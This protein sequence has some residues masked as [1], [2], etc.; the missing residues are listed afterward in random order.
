M[1]DALK[2]PYPSLLLPAEWEPQRAVWFTWPQ[3]AETWTPVW[4]E[5]RAAYRE[6]I[7]AAV[8]CQDVNVLVND[9]ATRDRLAAEFADAALGPH[10]LDFPVY[11]TNDSWIRDYGAIT[12][13]APAPGGGSRLLALDFGFNSWGGKYPPWDK[14]DAAPRFMAAARGRECL[15]VDLVLE[16]GSIDANG[17][18]LLLTTS[19]CLLNP[20]R[21]PGLDRGKLETALHGWLGAERVLWLDSGI[22]GDDTD[23][24]VD[25]LARFADARTVLC[26]IETDQRDENYEPLKRN[27]E[28]L[29]RAARTIDLE[30]IEIP[31]PARLV[32]ADLRTPAT[33]LNF[34]ILNG[35][36]LVPV[37]RDRRDD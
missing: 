25:D 24:H 27:I 18:G 7:R 37:F 2:P 23:G 19:Q 15:A 6:I 8:R 32:K 21:N 29:N 20:N 31:M 14:D 13:R 10:R 11:P 33:Y 3:N 17:K 12:V 9:A 4:D 36:V 1:H 5:A 34:L 26:A 35:A 28:A 30:V 16:G 22:H